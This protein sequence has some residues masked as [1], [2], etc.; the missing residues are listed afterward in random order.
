[1][2][3]IS[4]E[5]EFTG[6]S[7][8]VYAITYGHN[9][10]TFFTGSGDK[11]VA[12]WNL[13]TK[14][15]ERF[16]IQ[17]P[18]QVYA[19][20]H[21]VALKMLV[22]GNAEGGIHWVDLAKKEEVNYF[23]YHQK[24]IFNLIYS[25]N[26][27][28]LIA[29]SGDG[30]LSVWDALKRTHLRTLYLC[31][32]KVRGLAVSPDG[33]LLAVGSGDNVIRIFDTEHFNEIHTLKQHTDSVNCLCFHP[34]LPILVSGGKDAYLNVWDA[35]NEFQLIKSLPAHNYAIYG[36]DFSPNGK[37]MASCSRDKTIKIWATLD[38][39]LICRIDARKFKSHSHSVNKILWH[40]YRDELVSAGDDR[41]ILVWKLTEQFLN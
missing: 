37:Y 21:I 30:S 14:E 34:T 31:E 8:G 36:L 32:E 11:F 17:L 33:K 38:F 15:P 23:T 4:K 9:E 19:L 35:A 41:K 2:I 27:H 10:N 16:A 25:P 28:Q 1:M 26:Y 12:E 6:H 3:T 5:G 20:C 40:K 24:G 29:A 7:S 39:E 13:F 18:S 22:V